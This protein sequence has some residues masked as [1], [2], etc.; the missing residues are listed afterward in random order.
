MM[1]RASDP[2]PAYA[3]SLFSAGWE[4]VPSQNFYPHES[5]AND[6]EGQARHYLPRLFRSQAM[7]NGQ[8]AEQDKG[9]SANLLHEI[10]HRCSRLAQAAARSPA[11]CRGMQSAGYAL[12]GITDQSVR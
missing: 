6:C 8:P 2:I 7:D 10:R 9:K 3:S 4:F 12:N 5:R 11:Y 1:Q